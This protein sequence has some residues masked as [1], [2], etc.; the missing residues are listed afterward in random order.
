MTQARMDERL[1]EIV[2]QHSLSMVIVELCQMQSS[3][4]DSAWYQE[5]LTGNQKLILGLAQARILEMQGAFLPITLEGDQ[6]PG[7]GKEAH[8]LNEADVEGEPW[9]SPD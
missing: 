7:V 3:L 4:E 2:R 8:I 6:S 1:M 5:T 9:F